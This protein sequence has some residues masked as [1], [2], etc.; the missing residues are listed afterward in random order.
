MGFA[1]FAEYL[2]SQAISKKTSA[3]FH[4]T[5]RYFRGRIIDE[6][7]THSQPLPQLQKEL[8]TNYGLDDAERF[9]TIIKNLQTE[10]LISLYKKNGQTQVS[11]A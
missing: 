1:N 8:A 4:T 6:L 3:P 10:N 9:H 11:L 5:N 7:R 2:A